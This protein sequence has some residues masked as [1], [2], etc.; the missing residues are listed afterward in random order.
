MTKK[1]TSYEEAERLYIQENFSI[2]SIAAKLK[3]GQRTI[4]YWK[5]DN[6]W[7]IKKKNY[8]ESKSAFH[9]ELYEFSRELMQSIRKDVKNGEKV[10]PGRMFAFARMLPL[11]A[12]IKDY[13]D[14]VSNNESKSE[15]KGLTEEIINKIQE[16]ILGMKPRR[17]L[18]E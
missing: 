18:N 3:V 13:E 15:R 5:K 7:D 2:E 17:N 8:Q 16:E 11:I 9:Q 6:N 12:R 14:I 10:E 4:G 1:K